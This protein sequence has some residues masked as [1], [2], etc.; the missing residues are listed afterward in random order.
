MVRLKLSRPNGALHLVVSFSPVQDFD[1]ARVEGEWKVKRGLSG[2]P[3]AV[4]RIHLPRYAAGCFRGTLTLHLNA[5]ETPPPPATALRAPTRP[6]SALL[7]ALTPKPC[8]VPRRHLLS[9][10]PA[11]IG[12]GKPRRESGFWAIGGHRRA[13]VAPLRAVLK[14]RQRGSTAVNGSCGRGQRNKVRHHHGR[15]WRQCQAMKRH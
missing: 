5:L 7:A 11:L 3:L 4:P 1:S 10:P 2:M 6:D 12:S 15:L 8:E 14:Q 13:M 9:A